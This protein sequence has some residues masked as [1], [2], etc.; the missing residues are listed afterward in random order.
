MKDVIYLIFDLLTTLATL[1]RPVGSRTVIAEYLLQKQ[2]FIIYSRSRLRAPNL[3]TQDPTIL[4]L[5][6]LFLNPRRITREAMFL[7]PSTLLSLH[8][9]LNKREYRL[10]C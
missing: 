7:K 1:L 4:G 3:T 10:L 5:L 6:S 9:T 2:Q 8:N